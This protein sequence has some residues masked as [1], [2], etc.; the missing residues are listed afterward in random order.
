MRAMVYGGLYEPPAPTVK[1]AV[2]ADT[3]TAHF[4][5][6]V[7]LPLFVVLA[8]AKATAGSQVFYWWNARVPLKWALVEFGDFLFVLGWAATGLMALG[9]IVRWPALRRMLRWGYLLASTV[10]VFYAVAN[11]WIFWSMHTPLTYPLIMMAGGLT[12]VR[13]SLT[14]YITTSSI[15]ALIGVP[16]AYL[17]SVY[18]GLRVRRLGNRTTLAMLAAAVGM[19]CPVGVYGYR[20]FVAD[21]RYEVLARNPQWVLL[22]S[23]VD[24]W[25]GNKPPALR[26]VG[27][28]SN[29]DDFRLA[30]DRPALDMAGRAPSPIKNVIEVVLE[31]TG[32]QFLGVYGSN[33]HTT[34]NLE[35]EAKN[36]LIYRNVCS[37]D[38]YTVFSMMPLVLSI[39]PGNGWISYVNQYPR[40]TGTTAAQVLRDRGYRTAFMTSG[41]LNFFNSRRFFENRGFDVLQGCEDFQKL[42][43]GTMISSWGMDDTPLFDQMLQWIEREPGKPFYMMAWTQQT[44]HPYVTAPGQPITP[45]GGDSTTEGQMFNRYL[46]NLVLE[47]AQ[48][49]RL[50][51]ALRER[52]LDQNTLVVIT[53]D[54][55]ETF[56]FPHPYFAHGTALYQECVNVPC[57]FWSPV[58][59]KSGSRSDVIGSHV[60]L[61]PTIFDLMG[62]AM[63]AS[64]QGFS[65]MDPSRPQ[66]S[67][68]STFTGNLLEGMREGNN[69]FIYNVTLQREELYDLASDPTEQH[70]EFAKRPDLCKIYRERLSALA[71]FERTHLQTLTAGCMP[72]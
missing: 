44:H 55:G 26:D 49:G 47:D 17:G 5:L 10:F 24:H 70:N 72:K 8:F 36:S 4:L 27:P 6:A 71:N 14:S 19:Y 67:Y 21:S 59:F 9:G 30:G 34:P 35:T 69:K 60:D 66:R 51:A 22:Q 38:G 48:L 45:M 58:L 13:S 61:N 64:W 39:Y 42:G 12:D 33:Y 3:S 23:Y 7:C 56:G 2:L 50:F 31:S 1:P 54:H 65:L 52:H 28:A 57:I 15:A 32:T 11:V 29:R 53:G 68:F 63:P 20:H 25:R 16:L 18:M 62:I 46:N 40:L 41:V 37:N 43:V